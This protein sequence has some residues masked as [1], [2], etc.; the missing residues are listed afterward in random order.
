MRYCLAVAGS[1][2]FVKSFDTSGGFVQNGKGGMRVPARRRKAYL[3][4]TMVRLFLCV[5]SRE[6]Y[7][8]PR[9]GG[10]TKA[11]PNEWGPAEVRNPGGAR[12]RVPQL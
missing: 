3:D 5:L 12:P 7:G 9:E 4:H 10:G 11:G 1:R 2:F 6:G 8:G